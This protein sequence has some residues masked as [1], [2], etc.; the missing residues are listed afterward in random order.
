MDARFIPV[1]TDTDRTAPLK[2]R[3]YLA[4]VKRGMAY[5][6]VS[7]YISE[8]VFSMVTAH[9]IKL[10]PRPSQENEFKAQRLSRTVGKGC[11]TRPM[12]CIMICELLFV[13][14]GQSDTERRRYHRKVAAEFAGSMWDLLYTTDPGYTCKEHQRTVGADEDVRTQSHGLFE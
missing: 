9:V 14:V 4:A 12:F 3:K 2:H 5:P 1:C 13:P 7:T 11:F 10:L 6:P 8:E